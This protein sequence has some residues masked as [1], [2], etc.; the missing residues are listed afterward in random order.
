MYIRCQHNRAV[1]YYP[2]AYDVAGFPFLWL[3]V[4]Y[5]PL[6]ISG[7]LDNKSIVHLSSWENFNDHT[8]KRCKRM[9]QLPRAVFME[10]WSPFWSQHGDCPVRL[11]RF[12][13]S[14]ANISLFEPPVIDWRKKRLGRLYQF[15]FLSITPP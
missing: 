4:G 1:H 8:E 2:R 7:K 6:S 5:R 11:L 3:V 12:F 15:L 10:I 13:S 14:P 9:P